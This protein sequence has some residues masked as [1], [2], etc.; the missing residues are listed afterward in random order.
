MYRVI[1]AT[2]FLLSAFASQSSPTS[3]ARLL[4][5]ANKNYRQLRPVEAIR[6]YREYL[7]LGPDR[8]DV[9][10]FLGA[11]LLNVNQP[12][13]ALVEAKHALVLDARFAKA[14][15]LEGRIFTAKEQWESA[16]QCFR[17]AL[18][19]A[20]DDSDT[21][22]F[23]GR[24]SYE[25]NRFGNAIRE[26]R[27][28]LKIGSAQSRVY[29]NLGLAY[30]ALNRGDEAER[31]YGQAVAL[32]GQHYRPMFAL[33]RFLFKQGRT[34]EALPLLEAALRLAPDATEV[35]F[36]LGRVLYQSHRFDEA[37]DV[38]KGGIPT[39]DCRLYGLLA[40]IHRVEGAADAADKDLALWRDCSARVYSLE[41]AR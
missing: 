29:E 7:R 8:A 26:F 39:D 11:A 36:E 24:A 38:L 35:R 1:L 23:S 18:E 25:A 19:L 33:G 20:P 17:K 27:Q 13:E 32:D 40:K 30:E 2:V 6:L 15:T 3:A 4:E 5:E 37:A 21:W 22:Y 9:R 16:S 31:A 28:A 41:Q 10:V 34:S 12:D 14:Y